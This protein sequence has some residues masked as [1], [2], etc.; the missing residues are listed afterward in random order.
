M[1]TS[2]LVFQTV[3]TVVTPTLWRSGVCYGRLIEVYQ[4]NSSEDC[5]DSCIMSDQKCEWATFES[6]RKVCHLSKA[7]YKVLPYSDHAYANKNARK[8]KQY[9][10]QVKLQFLLN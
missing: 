6:D 5:L 7:C 8:G 10:F 3:F 4:G 2:Y 1:L 9:Y